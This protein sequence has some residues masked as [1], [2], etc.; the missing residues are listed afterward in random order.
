MKELDLG[1]GK[2]YR[3]LR[4]L[5]SKNLPNI[6]N[7]DKPDVEMGYVEPGHGMKGRKV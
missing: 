1:A 7:V 4:R 3:S 6:P 5:I 2:D